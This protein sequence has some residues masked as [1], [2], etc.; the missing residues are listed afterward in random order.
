[1]GATKGVGNMF[2]LPHGERGFSGGDADGLIRHGGI[3]G[4]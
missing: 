1:V 2:R 3:A 4:T